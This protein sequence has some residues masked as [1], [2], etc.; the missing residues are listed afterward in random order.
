MSSLIS[1]MSVEQAGLTAARSP[2]LT[3][4]MDKLAA[5]LGEPLPGHLNRHAQVL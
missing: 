2:R 5:A 1:P 3:L 4:R